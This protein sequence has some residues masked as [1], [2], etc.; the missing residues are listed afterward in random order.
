M[1]SARGAFLIVQSRGAS[2]SGDGL[3]VAG[4][5]PLLHVALFHILP[6]GDHGLDVGGDGV[7]GGGHVDVDDD[8]AQDRE[9]TGRMDEGDR[10]QR[11]PAQP[12]GAPR[13][14]SPVEKTREHLNGQQKGGQRQIDDPLERVVLGV[15]AL[16]HRMAFA[17]ENA[18]AV[19][20][21][22]LEHL[23]GGG[24]VLLPLSGR[25]DPEDEKGESPEPGQSD[26]IVHLDGLVE[27]Q[28]GKGPVYFEARDQQHEDQGHLEPMPEAFI[29][30][31]QVHGDHFPG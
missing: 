20:Q 25:K 26:G 31:V 5:L 21:D 16:G 12:P 4:F 18:V 27:A 2:P 8:E 7:A 22:H 9:G 15:P 13:V 24:D 6:A 1:S 14:V 11:E 23:S 30:G 3:A 10:V 17:P 28:E 29:T 19:I